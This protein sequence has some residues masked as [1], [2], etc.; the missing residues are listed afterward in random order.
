M[1]GSMNECHDRAVIS[2]FSPEQ[3]SIIK[4]DHFFVAESL[5]LYLCVCMCVYVCLQTDAI[6]PKRIKI[7]TPTIAI[8]ILYPIKNFFYHKNVMENH[9]ENIN[10]YR[11]A[12]GK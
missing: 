8:T 11:T 5:K 2:G 7:P 10:H 1:S 9:S 3:C 6:V 4:T 12:Y